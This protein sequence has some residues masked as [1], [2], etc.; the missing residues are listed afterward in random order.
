[1]AGPVRV[2]FVGTGDAFGSGGRLQTCIHVAG[3]GAS[4]LLDCGCSSLVGLRRSGIAPE[5]IDTVIISHLHGDHFGGIPFLLLD[6]QYLSKRTSPLAIIGPQ[7]L[8][9]QVAAA[10]AALY[11][12][13]LEDGVAF[14]VT[15]Q[16]LQPGQTLC[17][18]D[19]KIR[20]WRMQHGGSDRALGVQ[21]DGCGKRIAY[22]GDTEWNEN[23]PLL[24]AGA[25]LLICEC[26]QYDQPTA[27]HLDYMTLL[28]K[29][30]QLD[31][32]QIVLTHAGDAVLQRQDALEFPLADDGFVLDL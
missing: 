14:P 10:L 5:Q 27:S 30:G 17:H 24:A 22:T 12:G 7:G 25:D 6:G 8:Q 28:E 18:G 9:K 1:M 3:P 15:Y 20:A 26:F 4:Y 31:C 13:T 16:E 32:R 11:P 21:V 29:R 19:L 23:L 2:S